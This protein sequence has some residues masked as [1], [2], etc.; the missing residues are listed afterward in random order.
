MFSALIAALERVP[1]ARTAERLEPERKVLKV[2]EARNERFS[3][4]CEHATGTLAA[5]TLRL[6]QICGYKRDVRI[7]CGAQVILQFPSAEAI[8]YP[9]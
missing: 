2:G 8:V 6:A 7:F 5:A 3:W 9:P 4:G 1:T